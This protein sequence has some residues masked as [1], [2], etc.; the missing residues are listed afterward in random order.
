MSRTPAEWMVPLDE[1]ILEILQ[2]E[3]WSSPAYI[4]RKVSLWASVGRVRERCR[5]LTYAQMIEP[6]TPR[7]E[8]YDITGFGLRY[9]E[10]RLDASKQPR[11]SAREVLNS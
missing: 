2:A 11:P 1:R 7:F 10:G 8:N 9:L 5:M 6:L 4:A 3:G